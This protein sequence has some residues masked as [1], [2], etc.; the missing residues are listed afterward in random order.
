[1]ESVYPHFTRFTLCRISLFIHYTLLVPW[2]EFEKSEFDM[3]MQNP[4]IEGNQFEQC[5][6]FGEESSYGHIILMCA[7]IFWFVVRRDFEHSSYCDDAHKPTDLLRRF[8]QR[9]LISE[10]QFAFFVG[11]TIQL[12]VCLCQVVLQY[13]P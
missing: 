5:F 7:S 12:E 10:L 6:F 8:V 2:I 9:V 3:C 1:M 4:N 13:K 11:L